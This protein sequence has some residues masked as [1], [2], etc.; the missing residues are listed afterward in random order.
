[1]T[2]GKRTSVSDVELWRRTRIDGPPETGVTGSDANLIAALAEGRL[3]EDE[4]A[5]LEARMAA[6]PAVRDT[7]A[8]VRGDA[9]LVE[10]ITPPARLAARA[11]A[12]FEAEQPAGTA[13]SRGVPSWLRLGLQW[14]ATAA[15]LVVVGYVGFDLGQETRNNTA[16]VDMLVSVEAKID[17]DAS[18][19][20][21]IRALAASPAKGGAR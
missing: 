17:F 2:N 14:S 21:L 16:R 4:R 15:A 3:S 7:V 19:D 18:D 8:A 6:S 11:R 20:T 12:A 9:R 1:M 10:P 13:R 5:A